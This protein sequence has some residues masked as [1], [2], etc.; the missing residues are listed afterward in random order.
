MPAFHL[1]RQAAGDL[2]DI[3]HYTRQR[4]GKAAAVRYAG[5]L[6]RCLDLLAVRP[7]AGRRREELRPADLHSFVHGRHVIFYQPRSQ[8]V[9]ILRVLHAA[10]DV[11]RHLG[12]QE[13]P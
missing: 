4:W 3:Y 2:Q 5:Q 6:R 7:H 13:A 12:T 9:L 1:T 11:S 8:G 10:R